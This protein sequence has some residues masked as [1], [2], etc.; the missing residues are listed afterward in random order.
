MFDHQ[1]ATIPLDVLPDP[2]IS[3]VVSNPTD[4]IYYPAW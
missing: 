4:P 2:M 3:H 1:T